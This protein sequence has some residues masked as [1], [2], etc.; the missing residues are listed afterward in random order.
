MPFATICWRP[1]YSEDL[2]L[3]PWSI[4]ATQPIFRPNFIFIIPMLIILAMGWDMGS[5][6][7]GFMTRGR[8]NRWF[9]CGPTINDRLCCLCSTIMYQMLNNND[10]LACVAPSIAHFHTSIATSV[11]HFLGPAW[12]QGPKRP[13]WLPVKYLKGNQKN[14][15]TR[16]KA[17][18]KDVLAGGWRRRNLNW[19]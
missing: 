2:F 12:K 5:W 3:T 16:G 7:P 4:I 18:Y 13:P 1:W 17:G 19:I 11:T 9:N 10:S 14:L 6:E 15:L 8:A